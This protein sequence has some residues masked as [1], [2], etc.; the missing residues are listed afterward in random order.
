MAGY[1]K[2]HI[3]QKRATDSYKA[4]ESSDFNLYDKTGNKIY[5]FAL[6]YIIDETWLKYGSKGVNEV[7]DFIYEERL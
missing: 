5:R 1:I 7:V 3:T 6:K 2:W 4:I